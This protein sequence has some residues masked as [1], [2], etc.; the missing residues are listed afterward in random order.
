MFARRSGRRLDRLSPECNET[1]TIAA[2]IGREFTLDQIAQLTADFS[3]EQLLDVLEEALAAHVLEEP[4]GGAG[5]YQFT[6]AL[7]QGT[8]LDELSL[9]RRARL[10]ARIAEA[11]EDLYGERAEAHAAELA[12]HFAEAETVPGVGE[13]RPLLPARG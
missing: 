2:A 3:D 4:L 11:L 7:I 8:L 13:A 9:T 6:H 12:H 1:L 10:H 5:R